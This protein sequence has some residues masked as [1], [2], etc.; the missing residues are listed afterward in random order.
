M[1][2]QPHATLLLGV[3]LSGCAGFDE[4]PRTE[5]AQT[6]RPVSMKIGVGENAAAGDYTRV[7]LVNVGAQ[8]RAIDGKKLG[9]LISA[10]SGTL[11]TEAHVPPGS[12]RITA[13]YT[14]GFLSTGS[15]SSWKE[16]E[17]ELNVNTRAGH[18]YT[19]RARRMQSNR[20]EFSVVDHGPGYDAKCGDL[21]GRPANPLRA[22]NDFSTGVGVP[23]RCH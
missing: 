17:S 9:P 23:D 7:R 6:T 18:V 10:E 3:L 11:L 20:V 12:H 4:P 22:F 19:I 21:F 16:A 15:F 13:A 8:V 2:L 1:N 5:F 14:E